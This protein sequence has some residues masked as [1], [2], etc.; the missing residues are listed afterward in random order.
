MLGA[1][2]GDLAGSIYEFDE[3]KSKKINIEKR[4]EI[5]TK[6]DLI[7]KDSFYSDDTILT[8]AI[9]DAIL[10]EIPYGEALKEYGLKYYQNEPET[11]ANHFKYMFSP[12][13]IKWCK[14]KSDGHSI[15][16]GALMRISPIGYLFNDLDRVMEESKK[17]T[18][19]SHN[20]NLAIVTSQKLN[21]L[22][23]MGRKG[24]SKDYIKNNF[25]PF[26]KEIDEIRLFN[27]FDSSCSVFD[28]CVMAFLASNS[29][30]DAVRKAVSLGGDTDTIGA[31]TGS[32]AE[33]FYGVP[34]ELKNQALDK[35]PNNFV[36]KL[37]KGY[38]KVKKL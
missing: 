35:L 6:D 27:V 32:I 19:P 8:I 14:G 5:L 3:F 16:N 30:E 15:G 29:F 38:Q 36:L 4:K 33:A 26:T 17:A 9:L 12:G 22:I 7:D 25:Y 28:K 34:D 31:I 37:E 18:I 10:S 23:Y 21:T 20:S 2:I 24:Y 13:F 1:I 11:Q